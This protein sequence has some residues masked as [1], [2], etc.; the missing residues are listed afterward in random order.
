AGFYRSSFSLTAAGVV[1]LFNAGRYSEKEIT[2][3]L[4][5]LLRKCDL[6][7]DR[8]RHHYFYWYG[9]YYAVQAMYM[10]GGRYWETYYP[11]LREE[12]VESQRSKGY[13][14]NSTGPGENFATAVAVII[15]QIP[16]NYLPIFQR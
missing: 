7:S 3:S 13:W 15:L 8:W 4:D 1:S 14:E 12:L 10:A 11:R 16:F 2:S 5:Y 6:V 9:H